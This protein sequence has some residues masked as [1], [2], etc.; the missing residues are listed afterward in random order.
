ML[1]TS[2]SLAR[3]S[4]PS[5]APPAVG[6]APT[7]DARVDVLAEQML[8]LIKADTEDY[9]WHKAVSDPAH[10]SIV[11][12]IAAALRQPVLDVKDKVR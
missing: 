9:V 10:A 12:A 2:P 6:G 7:V 1:M 5:S 3:P 11:G 4:R 8:E